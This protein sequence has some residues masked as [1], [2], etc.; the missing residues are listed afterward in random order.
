ME[1]QG[2]GKIVIMAGVVLT[3]VGVLM[4]IAPKLPF[5]GK[6]PGDFYFKKAG[7][8]FYFP[9]ATSVIV[10]IVLSILLSFFFRGK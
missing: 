8:S 6:L 4:L 2:P 1:I 5:I 7:V 9:L 3:A 10:S